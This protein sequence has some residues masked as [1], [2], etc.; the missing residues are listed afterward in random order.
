MSSLAKDTRTKAL[1]F[2]VIRL[3]YDPSNIKAD[4]E[5]IENK[6]AY[7][8]ALKKQLKLLTTEH[9]QAKEITNLEI[10]NERLFTLIA[11]Q[12]IQIQK[13]EMDMEALLKEKE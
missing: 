6:N 10:E 12:K 5:M 8:Q 7:I 3:G 13:M 4:E 2:L 11:E 9:P 1:E